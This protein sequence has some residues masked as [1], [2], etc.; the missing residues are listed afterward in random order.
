[1]IF[2]KFFQ[3]FT[4]FGAHTRNILIVTERNCD[5]RSCFCCCIMNMLYATKS[6]SLYIYMFVCM[7]FTSTCRSHFLNFL[8]TLNNLFL[9]ISSVY[10]IYLYYLLNKNVFLFFFTVICE[11]LTLMYVCT[12]VCYYFHKWDESFIFSPLLCFN[13]VVVKISNS[14]FIKNI[15]L[16]NFIL[17]S[18]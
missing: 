12:P 6:L 16:K 4:S 17:P 3:Y 14:V 7:Y 10:E 2:Y 1:M 8:I 5:S 9:V 18:W 13:V 11:H 15:W